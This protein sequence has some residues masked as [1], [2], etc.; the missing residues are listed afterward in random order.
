MV[1]F[2]WICW[3]PQQ[4]VLWTGGCLKPQVRDEIVFSKFTVPNWRFWETWLNSF[5]LIYDYEDP[6]LGHDRA[7]QCIQRWYC[8]VS[9]CSAWYCKTPPTDRIVQRTPLHILNFS[10]R[11]S[12]FPLV[13][14]YTHSWFHNH[15]LFLI[16]SCQTNWSHHNPRRIVAPLFWKDWNQIAL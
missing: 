8:L 12:L 2:W 3:F 7:N 5:K 13:L 14:L 9:H 15:G 10:H 16:V 11:R 4:A 1:L 6:L